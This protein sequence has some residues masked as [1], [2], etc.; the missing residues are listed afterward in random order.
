M[1]RNQRTSVGCLITIIGLWINKNGTKNEKQ[2]HYDVH[3]D[4]EAY[5]EQNKTIPF[6]STIDVLNFC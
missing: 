1:Q 4:S 3:G 2:Q 6:N 5:G